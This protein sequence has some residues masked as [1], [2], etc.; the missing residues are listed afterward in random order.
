MLFG[1]RAGTLP[2]EEGRTIVYEKDAVSA[3]GEVVLQ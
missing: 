3:V 1:G 2:C